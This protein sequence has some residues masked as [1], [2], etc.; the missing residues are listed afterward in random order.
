MGQLL[1]MSC[2]KDIN[3]TES[4]EVCYLIFIIQETIGNPDKN[5][6]RNKMKAAKS[7]NTKRGP[8]KPERIK[9][10]T[11]INCI[12]RLQRAYTKYRKARVS[13]SKSNR[14]VN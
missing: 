5:Q 11:E 10:L 12:I 8:N 1:M 14:P 2:S 7:G 3:L 9:Y 6:D 4:N 13:R